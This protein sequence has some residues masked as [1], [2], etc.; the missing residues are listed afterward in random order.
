MPTP[1]TS[2]PTEMPSGLETSVL[3]T[4]PFGS[5]NRTSKLVISSLIIVITAAHGL[6]LQYDNGV[7]H[8]RYTLE[9]KKTENIQKY[10][11][12]VG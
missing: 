5:K 11:D 2:T 4:I 12:E 9:D 3:Q 1:F 10:F 7:H 8:F 6:H